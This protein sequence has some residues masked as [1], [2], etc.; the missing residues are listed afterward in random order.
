MERAESDVQV[1]THVLEAVQAFHEEAGEK[2]GARDQYEAFLT[3]W[4]DA[5]PG[6]PILQQ[7]RAEHAKLQ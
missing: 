1:L 5:D 6:V 2:I 7:A 4:K 3:L